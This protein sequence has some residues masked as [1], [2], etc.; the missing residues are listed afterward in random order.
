MKTEVVMFVPKDG[1]Y[2]IKSKSKKVELVGNVKKIKTLILNKYTTHFY[3]T[4]NL[5]TLILD[6]DTEYI[7]FSGRDLESIQFNNKLKEISA[8]TFS[9]NTNLKEINLPND[10]GHI[11]NCAFEYC[12]NL[13][14]INFNSN[15]NIIGS[16]SFCDCSNIKTLD[17]SK[18][19][20]LLYIYNDGFSNCSS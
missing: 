14:T 10:L 7:K 12:S 18:I 2:K 9:Y 11:N 19:N 8:Y 1:A 15:L 5:K 3:G 4:P 20:N 16:Y 17:F 13:E 6:K